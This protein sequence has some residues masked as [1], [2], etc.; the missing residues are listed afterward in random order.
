MHIYIFVH[1]HTIVH[2]LMY[3]HYHNGTFSHA[4]THR[5]MFFMY[6]HIMV[7]FFIYSTQVMVNF[8]IDLHTMILSHGCPH[9]LETTEA[10]RRT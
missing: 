1:A 10:I 9:F 8:H 3:T 2:F 4:C 5:K 7:D 6:T